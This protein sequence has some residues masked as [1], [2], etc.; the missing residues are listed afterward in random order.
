QL[1]SIAELHAAIALRREAGD[2]P[3]EAEATARLVPR[4]L[5]RGPLDEAR[6]VA[7]RAVAL[8]AATPGSR[9]S[10][11]GTGQLAHVLLVQGDLDGAIDLGRQA[12]AVAA[13]FDDV[14]VVDTTITVGHAELVRDGPG[15]VATLERAIALERR[16]GPEAAVPRALDSLAYG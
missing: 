3:G 14:E 5:C 13:E 10:S 9:Q 2:V 8:L 7:E 4:I 1:D 15:H 16:H 11:A 6:A 12:L